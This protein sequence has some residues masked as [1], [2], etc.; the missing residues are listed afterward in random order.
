MMLAIYLPRDCVDAWPRSAQYDYTSIILRSR[1]SI[2]YWVG[3]LHCTNLSK[4]V[5]GLQ[6]R[7]LQVDKDQCLRVIEVPITLDRS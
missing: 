3:C 1:R 2:R 5:I 6:L 4:V 7:P